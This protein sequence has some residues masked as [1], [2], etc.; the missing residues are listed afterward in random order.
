MRGNGIV[1]FILGIGVVFLL[2][3]FALR[4]VAGLM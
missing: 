1:G 4:S 3:W 2:I